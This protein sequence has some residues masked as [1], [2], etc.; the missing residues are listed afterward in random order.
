MNQYTTTP[1]QDDKLKGIASLNSIHEVLPFDGYLMVIC[2]DDDFHYTIF[3]NDK[4]ETFSYRYPIAT[5]T[6]NLNLS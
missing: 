2:S 3:M 4:A 1:S 6:R 5:V